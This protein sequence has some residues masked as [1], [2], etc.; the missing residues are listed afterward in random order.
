MFA[1]VE[2]LNKASGNSPVPPDLEREVRQAMSMAP[3]FDGFG[4][5]LLRK[6]EE[7]KRFAE[8]AD[9]PLPV[10]VKHTPAQGKGWA[11]AETANFRIL[12]TQT[13]EV[14]ERVAR[15][16]E[17]T[18]VTMGRKWFGD[19]GEPWKPR[20]DIYLY[21][22]TQDY[23]LGTHQS[24]DCPGHSTI[25]TEGERVLG[26]RIDLH[27]D[28]PNMLTAVL[29]HEATHVVLAGRFGRN[30]V[31][32]WADEGMAVLSE[33]R[34][35]V[36]LH[37][38]N[39]PLHSREQQLFRTGDLMQLDKYPEPRRIGAF[40]AQSV[41]LVEFLSKEKGPRV[42]AQF[43]RDGLDGGYEQALRRHY[44]IAG[45]AEL[46]QRWQRYAL[47]NGAGSPTLVER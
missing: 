32:R 12:H 23:V 1:V 44:N 11:M 7:H 39:L 28:E 40:Y 47:G 34:E 17:T 31:P 10:E 21:P 30:A 2:L 42:F 27:C 36:E 41:S 37:L 43:L 14:A 15:I 18:R 8:R 25:S 5:D 26:R 38:R 19:P 24:A 35:R 45:F 46:D 6:I 13:A 33:P 9:E 22:N 3:K 16:A 4:K 29:P 20:C